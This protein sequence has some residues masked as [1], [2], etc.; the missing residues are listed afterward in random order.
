MAQ[1]RQQVGWDAKLGLV[2]DVYWFGVPDLHATFHK[3]GD[4][5]QTL[6]ALDADVRAAALE[7][8]TSTRAEIGRLLYV[9]SPSFKSTSDRFDIVHTQLTA[10]E[11][12][13]SSA[14]RAYDALSTAESLVTLRNVTPQTVTVADYAD[15]PTTG[16][17]GKVTTTRQQVGSH[18]EPNP[19]YAIA[20][21]AAVAGKLEAE[22]RVKEMNE[23]INAQRDNLPQ[24]QLRGVDANLVGLL[25][26]FGQPRF[27]VWSF[28]SYDIDQA[29]DQVSDLRGAAHAAAESVRPEHT[30]LDRSINRSIDMRW[31]ALQSPTQ[32]QS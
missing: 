21:A 10:A 6:V 14:E 9:E 4:D 19:A 15:V 25:D 1:L 13:E 32:D 11:S 17:D 5:T 22:A 27:L 3:G 20:N 28:D 18:Q 2:A 23:T 12:I 26:L 29:K 7:A 24:G 31:D 30:R 8:R 16:A